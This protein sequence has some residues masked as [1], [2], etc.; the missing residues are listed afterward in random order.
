MATMIVPIVKDKSKDITR[1]DNYRPVAIVT[2]MSKLFELC[3]L[4]RIEN[5][6]ATSDYQF[7]FKRKHSTEMCIFVVKEIVDFYKSHNSP[8]FACFMDATKAFDR[9]NHW[10]LFNKL[11]DRGIPSFIVRCLLYWYRGQTF[12]VRWA[13]E[14]STPFEVANGVRQGSVL[15]PTLFAIYID[16]LSIRLQKAGV[17]CHLAGNIMNHLFYADDIVLVSPSVKSLNKLV[18][19]CE[20]YGEEFDIL[21]HTTKTECMSFF[22]NN[23]GL[24]RIPSVYL[25]GKPLDF[26]TVKKYLGYMVSSNGDDEADMR[27]QLRCIYARANFILRK[28]SLCSE[29]VKCTLFRSFLYSIYCLNVWCDYRTKIVNTLRVAYN[30]AI[31]LIFN[32]K[33]A[34]SAS[35]NSVNRNILNFESLQ[36]KQL[37]NFSHRLLGSENV[38][39]RTCVNSDVFFLSKFWVH[40]RRCMY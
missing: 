12:C 17:G 9:V 15:S 23:L 31:R 37:Y 20:C 6:I 2:V 10:K 1:V 4:N 11:L 24:T 5:F 32:L 22:P 18:E 13:S 39:V 30:N 14:L 19:I 27:R 38:L 33:R 25:Y 21:F 35:G 36:R 34:S 26:V 7:G 8:V 40:F 3:I 16:D 28:F 29:S